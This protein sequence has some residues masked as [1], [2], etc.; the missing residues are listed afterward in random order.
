MHPIT[1]KFKHPAQSNEYVA[2]GGAVKVETAAVM[3]QPAAAVV[4][5]QVIGEMKEV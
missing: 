2:V 4:L 1:T 3:A 5:P